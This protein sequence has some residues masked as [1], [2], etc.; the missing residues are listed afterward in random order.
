MPIPFYKSSNRNFT[1]LHGDCIE[2]L[3]QFDFKFDMIFADPP[4]FLSNGGFSVHC[5]RVVGVD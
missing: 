1:L 2:L 5:G 3:K 4:D